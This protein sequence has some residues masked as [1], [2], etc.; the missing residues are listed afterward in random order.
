[1][2]QVGIF[3]VHI[4]QMGKQRHKRLENTAQVTISQHQSQ[5]MNQNSVAPE[6]VSLMDYTTQPFIHFMNKPGEQTPAI[7]SFIHGHNSQRNF[8]LSGRKKEA[9]YIYASS[10]TVHFLTTSVLW[11]LSRTGTCSMSIILKWMMYW[12]TSSIG[13]TSQRQSEIHPPI[14]SKLI[15]PLAV[16]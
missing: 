5:T 9:E 11:T 16:K 14:Q 12:E 4:L 10:E 6:P 2:S 8:L 3:I 1:M 13:E 7:L 15:F